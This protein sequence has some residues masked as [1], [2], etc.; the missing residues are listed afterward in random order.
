MARSRGQVI[1]VAALGIAVT[2]V[3]LAL[4]TNTAIYTENLATRSTVSGQDAIA[5][6]QSMEEGAGGLLALA[7]RYNATNYTTIQTQFESDVGNLSTATELESVR[8]GDL[9]TVSVSN[10]TEGAQI[11]QNEKRNFTDANTNT[12][13]TLAT[14]VSQTRRFEMNVTRAELNASDPFTVNVSNGSAHWTAEIGTDGTNITVANDTETVCSVDAASAVIDLTEGTVDG[15]QCD[16]LA[17]ASTVDGPYDIAFENADNGYGRYV[18]FV[19]R[20]ADEIDPGHYGSV[21]AI[22]AAIF[23]A[24]VHVSVDQPDLLYETN[25]TVAPEASPEGEVYGIVP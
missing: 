16:G 4:I 9:A 23:D 20:P 17:F 13:W 2:L 12:A 19:D 15:E 14:N 21:P 18:L 24:T 22:D 1:L 11:S 6:E 8:H 7:N 25:V 5:F 10:T 3:A